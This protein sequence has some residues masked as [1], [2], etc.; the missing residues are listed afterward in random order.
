ML[1]QTKAKPAFIRHFSSVNQAKDGI[2]TLSLKSY[3]VARKEYKKTTSEKY[4]PKFSFDL[5]D[6]KGIH[7]FSTSKM[8]PIP[9]MNIGARVNAGIKIML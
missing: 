3:L 2:K 4:I 6:G 8:G 5:L 1:G 7:L 9:S